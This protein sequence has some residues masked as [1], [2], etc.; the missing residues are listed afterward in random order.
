MH[1]TQPPGTHNEI[2]E[3]CCYQC[4]GS[5]TYKSSY[6]LL[7]SNTS[8]DH[9]GVRGGRE[10][11]G[12]EKHSK[13]PKFKG[14]FKELLKKWEK[15]KQTAGSHLNQLIFYNRS[16]T[17]CFLVFPL[18]ESSQNCTTQYRWKMHPIFPC[19]FNLLSFLDT[20]SNF[21]NFSN[22]LDVPFWINLERKQ[23][24]IA[25]SSLFSR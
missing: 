20:W 1:I 17:P 14:Q 24:P 7:N 15:R 3:E 19:K 11:E 16:H 18:T 21:N 10:W 22:T 5:E 13:R 8:G 9:E 25:P 6:L 23:W 2:Q 12:R 4:L